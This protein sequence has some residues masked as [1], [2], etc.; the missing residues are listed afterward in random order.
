M[1]FYHKPAVDEMCSPHCW[2][3]VSLIT[4]ENQRP[5]HGFGNVKKLLKD[6]KRRREA[7]GPFSFW[8]L[9]WGSG[10]TGFPLS[11]PWRVWGGRWGRTGNDGT[12]HW[13][14]VRRSGGRM[15]GVHSWARELW[16]GLLPKLVGVSVPPITIC[17]LLTISE[18]YRQADHY[19]CKLFI[20]V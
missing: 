2:K 1:F 19:L 16:P 8:P 6:C 20:T 10:G 7:L 3:R 17:F 14:R 4:K 11:T 9:G 5:G 12:G 18:I 15:G 13:V